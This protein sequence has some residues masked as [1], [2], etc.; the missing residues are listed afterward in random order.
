MRIVLVAWVGHNAGV[1]C[2]I[3]STSLSTVPSSM[4]NPITCFQLS[5]DVQQSVTTP[6]TLLKKWKLAT[7]SEYQ[8]ITTVLV[9]YR[10]VV[11]LLLYHSVTKNE[12]LLVSTSLY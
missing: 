3:R 8:S 7:V 5:A 6:C 4:K 1:E 9:T 2:S 12:N 11:N 10:K